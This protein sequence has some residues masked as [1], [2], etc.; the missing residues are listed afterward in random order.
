MKGYPKY[1]ATKEDYENIIRDFPEWRQRVK[2]EL[3]VLKAVKDDK[4][5]VATTLIDP[6]N[7]EL[8]WNTKEMTNPNPRFKQKGF[9]TKKELGT[10]VTGIEEIGEVESG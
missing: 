6:N 2:T 5:V 10:M 7:E 1:F 8:G 9:K 4:M 3:D